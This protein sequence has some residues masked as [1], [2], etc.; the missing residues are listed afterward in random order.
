MT[1]KTTL[2]YSTY[3]IFDLKQLIEI[4]KKRKHQCQQ[5]IL[6]YK[7]WQVLYEM[8]T[9]LL[10]RKHA[11]EDGKVLRLHASNLIRSYWQVR[12]ECRMAINIYIQ[13][14]INKYAKAA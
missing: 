3:Q 14:H 12:S 4:E 13:K 10:A 9:D 7:K 2:S 1:Q 6:Q 11:A 5:A 8:E